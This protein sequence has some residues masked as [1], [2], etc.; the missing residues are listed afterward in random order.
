MKPIAVL[1]GLVLGVASGCVGP[2]PRYRVRTVT[3]APPP[4]LQEEIVRMS[5]AGLSD[6]VLIEKINTDGLEARPTAEQIASLK[7]EGVSDAVLRA[8]ISAP[9]RER[10]AERL[11]YTEPYPYEYS[12]YYS[13]WWHGPYWYGWPYWGWHLYPRSRWYF[14]GTAP[15][16]RYRP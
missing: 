16:P 8:M 1:L 5:K 13:P 3:P 11:I 9:V 10:T 14:H 15:H 2:A 7:K 6:A 12:Y 4:L